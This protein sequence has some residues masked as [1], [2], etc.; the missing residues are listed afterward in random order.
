MQTELS[1]KKCKYFFYY[2]SHQQLFGRVSHEW[3]SIL[4]AWGVVLFAFLFNDGASLTTFILGQ[5]WHS[6]PL[7]KNNNFYARKLLKTPKM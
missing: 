4:A 7:H 1:K 5:L 2:P 3:S 6:Y